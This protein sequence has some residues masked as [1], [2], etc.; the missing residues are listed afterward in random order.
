MFRAA[1]FHP[2]ARQAV[3]GVRFQSTI[4]V[5]SAKRSQPFRRF[6]FRLSLLTATF[7]LGGGFI[8]TKNDTVQD[9]FEDYVPF[10]DSVVSTID[11]YLYHRDELLSPFSRVN[12]SFADVK[13]KLG[14]EKTITIP[15]QGVQSDKVELKEAPAAG[16]TEVA[17]GR[18]LPLLHLESGD[19][20]I[21]STVNALNELIAALNLKVAS[22]ENYEVVESLQKSLLLLAEKYRAISLSKSQEQASLDDKLKAQLSEKE[23]ELTEEFVQKLE[24][25]K[26]QIEERHLRQLRVEVEAAR[27][28]IELEAANLIEQSKLAAIDEF[29]KVISEKIDS[30]RSA[31]LK[32]LEA[33]AARVADIEKYELELGKS[34]EMYFSYKEI[35]KSVSSLQKLLCTNE[36]SPKRGEELVAELTKLKQL[37]APLD[38][39]L[40]TEAV[41]ALPSNDKLLRSG[42]VL[43][44]SQLIS[45]WELLLPELRSVSLLPP[46]AGLVG[47]ISSLVFSKLLFSKSGKPVKTEDD[48]IGSDIESVIARVNNYLVKNELDNA[49]EEVSNMKG[50]ARRLADDWLVESRRKLELQFLIDLVDTEV[51]VSL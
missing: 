18:S 4:P 40:I 36:T 51:N 29:N 48:L 16:A 19:E 17:V 25:A 50:W 10:G 32:G 43:T 15:K 23:V 8:A 14:L 2:A 30:E 24:E 3:Y 12:D 45:R 44:Q 35:K 46:N 33:L 11:Y 22:F 21:D 31:K 1:K 13:E 49:V 42:G 38:N 37:V 47:H 6:L 34:A 26:K 27:Q 5:K 7:Y 28:K 9:L 20:V 41:A 39:Q